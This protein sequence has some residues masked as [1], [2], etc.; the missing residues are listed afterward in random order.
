[1][2]EPSRE[3]ITRA[4]KETLVAST[5][6]DGMPLISGFNSATNVIMA[7]FRATPSDGA[8]EAMAD[9]VKQLERMLEAECEEKYK[10]IAENLDLEGK[11]EVREKALRAP[12]DARTGREADRTCVRCDGSGYVGEPCI[13]NECPECN[14]QGSF[15]CSPTPQPKC[16]VQSRDVVIEQCASV[17][18][19]GDVETEAQATNAFQEGYAVGYQDTV[20]RFRQAI[21]ALALSSADK[22]CK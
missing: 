5:D 20:S 21:R 8:R 18:V 1:M 3:A 4:M 17:E 22:G 6:V 2:S 14:G 12:V 7:L 15:D 13:R 10:L 19:R 9:R 11:L 16:G